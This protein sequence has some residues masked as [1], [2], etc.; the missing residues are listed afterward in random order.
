MSTH[1][2]ES[3]FHRNGWAD[4]LREMCQA[5]D[6]TIKVPGDLPLYVAELYDALGVSIEVDPSAPPFKTHRHAQWNR[7]A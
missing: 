7:A 3:G 2:G 4:A 6:L 1:A 5:V